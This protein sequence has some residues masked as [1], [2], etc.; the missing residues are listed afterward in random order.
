MP[1]LRA[2]VH[3]VEPLGL[4][5]IITFPKKLQGMA[6]WQPTKDV[7]LEQQAETFSR[8]HSPSGK[9]PFWT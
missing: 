7:T 4:P 2:V 1:G 6:K 3:P 9:E 8:F 5:C